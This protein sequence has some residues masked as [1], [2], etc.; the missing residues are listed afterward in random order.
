MENAP[1]YFETKLGWKIA[2]RA[3]VH[4]QNGRR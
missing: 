4:P 3:E 2:L 1:I